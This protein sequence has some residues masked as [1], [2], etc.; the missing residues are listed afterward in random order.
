MTQLRR[1]FT[2]AKLAKE[3]DGEEVERPGHILLWG[4]LK[5]KTYGNT[6]P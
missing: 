6:E 2:V 1:Q 4:T 5:S 3:E